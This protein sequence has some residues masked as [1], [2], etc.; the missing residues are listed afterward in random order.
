M[1]QVKQANVQNGCPQH[2]CMLVP[3][4]R[5]STALLVALRRRSRWLLPEFSPA[6]H[7]HLR[8]PSSKLFPCRIP[9]GRSRGALS[10]GILEASAWG[11]YCCY[12]LSNCLD[13]FHPNTL[14]QSV[15]DVLGN[16]HADM[17]CF[18]SQSLER[19]HFVEEGASR[20]AEIAINFPS[21]KK[22]ILL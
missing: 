17:S 3:S 1:C 16:H 2:R 4:G 5:D 8:V 10:H 20:L 15:L 7:L 14:W 18:R 22:P 6:Q 12:Y 19:L 13:R 9:K 11:C 21:E